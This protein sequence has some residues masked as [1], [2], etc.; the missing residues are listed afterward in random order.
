M[1]ISTSAVA[2]SWFITVRSQRVNTIT[3]TAES[4]AGQY[5][6]DQHGIPSPSFGAIVS[7][8]TL[9]ASFDV[10]STYTCSCTVFVLSILVLYQYQKKNVS[11]T[12]SNT[13]SVSGFKY[14][15][16]TKRKEH[17]F[18]SFQVWKL[19]VALSLFPVMLTNFFCGGFQMLHLEQ[20]QLSE[21]QNHLSIP[22]NGAQ[23]VSL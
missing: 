19:S 5:Q 2:T 13:G 7:G 9:P 12:L 17:L 10:Y 11:W 6:R 1:C 4:I 3:Y 14:M 15:R 20:N 21:C 18:M 22:D 8:W 16:Y 23:A